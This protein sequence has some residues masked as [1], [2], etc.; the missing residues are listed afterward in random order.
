MAAYLDN[1][2][3]IQFQAHDIAS[4]QAI[5]N[6][7]HVR[8]NPTAGAMTTDLLDGKV[9]AIAAS[10]IKSSYVNMLT[11]NQVLDAIVGTQVVAA[12]LNDP[13]DQHSR[14]FTSV[15]PR[16]TD[17]ALPLTMCA[18]MTERSELSGRRYRGRM[19]LPPASD[20][21]A[22]LTTKWKAAQAYFI[23]CLAFQ[24][25]LLKLCQTAGAGH[26]GGALNDN[27]V[28]TFS[29][30]AEAAG[31]QTWSRVQSLP[32]LS[33]VHWLRSRERGTI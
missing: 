33:K 2:Y 15:G 4:G 20:G 16:G 14:S 23:N 29:R 24:T 7:F 11:V 28:V 10:A 25:E 30:A 32:I 6:T 31:A 17:L 9:A 8:Q 12:N 26:L 1:I 3:A 18:L 13:P 19:F 21:A 22:I 5:R 27:D